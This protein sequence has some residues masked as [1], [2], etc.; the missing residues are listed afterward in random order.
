[1]RRQRRVVPHACYLQSVN[2]R[3]PRKTTICHVRCAPASG[4]ARYILL[5]HYTSMSAKESSPFLRQRSE[6]PVIISSP[7]EATT[8]DSRRGSNS[9]TRS[10]PRSPRLARLRHGL[11]QIATWSLSRT[12]KQKKRQS[13]VSFDPNRSSFIAAGH[14]FE[15]VS[16]TNPHWC[17]HCGE[18]IWGLFTHAARCKRERHAIYL[19]CFLGEGRGVNPMATPTRVTRNGCESACVLIS[20][21]VVLI[22][23]GSTFVIVSSRCESHAWKLQ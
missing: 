2:Y 5:H 23:V 18:F 16:L 3:L 20:L 7:V 1:M 22:S 12:K 4:S 15:I 6:S 11:E 13:V 8:E 14:D 17:D 9:S 21:F 19:C 10:S